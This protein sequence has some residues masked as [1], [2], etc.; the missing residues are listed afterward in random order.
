VQVAIVKS[1][2]HVWPDLD[3]HIL[4]YWLMFCRAPREPDVL[5]LYFYLRIK[6]KTGNALHRKL[7]W[8]TAGGRCQMYIAGLRKQ[9]ENPGKK[10]VPM[11]SA[12][13]NNDGE[14]CQR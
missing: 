4:A 3:G 1:Q 10:A 6:S 11:L 5:Q 14:A 2:K 9:N 13:F 12:K 8:S 7:R